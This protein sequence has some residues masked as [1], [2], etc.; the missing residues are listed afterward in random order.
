M[1]LGGTGFRTDVEAHRE[2][3]RVFGREV[4]TLELVDPR[5]YHL[6]TALF[7]L[8]AEQIAYSPGRVLRREPRR[9]AAPLPRRDPRRRDTTRSCSD[10]TRMSDGRNVFLPAGADD[11]AAKLDAAGSRPSRSTCRSSARRAAA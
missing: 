5:F 9:A 8:D 7:A 10:A 6:D 3:E 1:I 4:V 11:L 2:V